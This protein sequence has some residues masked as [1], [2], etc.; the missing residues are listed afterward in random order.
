MTVAVADASVMVEIL[1]ST[2]SS[3]DRAR[4]RL[5]PHSVVAPHVL[6]FEVANALR[7]QVGRGVLAPERADVAH[8][9]L[10]TFPIQLWSY[11]PL[12]ARAWELRHNTTIY[13]AAYLALAELLDAPLLTLDRR[14]AGTPGVRCEVV[15]P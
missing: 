4:T 3:A 14:L 9:N 2:T 6:P 7:S 13:D 5:A 1:A 8:R 10:S 15:V 12:A 11:E